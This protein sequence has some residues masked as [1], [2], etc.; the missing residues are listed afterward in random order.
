[1]NID[2][3]RAVEPSSSSWS[4][5]EGSS[6]RTGPRRPAAFAAALAAAA[7]MVSGTPAVAERGYNLNQST[8]VDV[9]ILTSVHPSKVY[10]GPTK[11]GGNPRFTS[12]TF[13]TMDYYDDEV[14][15][16]VI[17]KI[18]VMTKTAA[19]LNAM[20]PPPPNPFMVTADAT[21][22]DDTGTTKDV[23]ITFTTTWPK[24]EPPTPPGYSLRV[25]TQ[26]APPGSAAS[27]YADY[28][29]S[30]AGAGARLTDVSFSTM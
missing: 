21:W 16:L 15:G 2:R 11:H 7:L 19:E 24:E 28:F 3:N 22:T 5:A 12:V 13:S 8:K 27:G 26:E 6:T 10:D 29:F 20:D 9:G 14:T 25:T 4:A 1:M 17:K 18:M 23:K 30:N